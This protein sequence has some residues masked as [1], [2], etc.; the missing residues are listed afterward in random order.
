MPALFQYCPHH[1]E[2][3][4]PTG[5]CFFCG[6]V[7]FVEVGVTTKQLD[8]MVELERVLQGDPGIT[9]ETRDKVIENFDAKA[10]AFNAALAT[11]RSQ[12]N[13]LA[14]QVQINADL[15]AVLLLGMALPNF[16][17][18][19]TTSLTIGTGSKSITCVLFGTA[20][21]PLI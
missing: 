16:A 6:G 20:L 17:G 14:A 21:T 15:A 18:T 8:R 19:S 3:K 10:F 7:N 2:Q 13:D 12:A 11:F 1:D 9:R 5:K 4:S